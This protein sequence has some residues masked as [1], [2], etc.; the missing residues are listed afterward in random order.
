MQTIK[1]KS[2]PIYGTRAPAKL[3]NLK[4]YIIQLY[5]STS[6]LILNNIKRALISQEYLR[7]FPIYGFMMISATFNNISVISWRSVLFVEETEIA[8]ENQAS[9]WQALSHSVVSS[10]PPHEL[11][12]NIP[13]ILISNEI[14][15]QLWSDSY[16][17]INMY[18]P[19][20]SYWSY[21][22]K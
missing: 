18:T 17:N 4:S 20:S 16:L 12:D 21:N 2:Y 22:W 13:L 3:I 6:L 10:T 5:W 8:R 1:H 15:K 11:H 19:T 14:I 7:T 9:Y